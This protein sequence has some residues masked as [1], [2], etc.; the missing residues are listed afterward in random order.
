MGAI[1]IPVGQ[2]FL[3]NF[4]SFQIWQMNT[5]I[6]RADLSYNGFHDASK[7]I[8]ELM[9]DTTCLTYLDLSSNRLGDVDMGHIVKGKSQFCV[10]KC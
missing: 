7:L 1:L 4:L 3:F 5:T 2:V 9:A 6:K 10:L 8:G